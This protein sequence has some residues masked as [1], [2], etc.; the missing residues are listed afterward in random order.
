MS[1]SFSRSG[2]ANYVRH[3]LVF[4]ILYWYVW[5]VLLPR[6]KKYSLEEEVRVLGDGTVVTKLVKVRND[7][8]HDSHG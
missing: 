6:W 5:T 7:V 4:A 2:T 8:L 3:S 1:Y